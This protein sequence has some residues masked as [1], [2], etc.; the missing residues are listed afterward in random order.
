M[1]RGHVGE[2]YVIAGPAM[3]YRETMDLFSKIT[4]IPS[5]K[6]WLPTWMTNGT[7]ATLGGLE[8]FGLRVPELSE[9]GLSVFADYTF[10]ASAE[11]AKRELGWQSRPV[12]ETLRGT[13][14]WLRA[15]SKQA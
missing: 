10:W 2:S 5:P 6:M 15:Q 3:T 11:K 4:G 9:E 12:E 8:A 13:L 14:D 7:S 1:E